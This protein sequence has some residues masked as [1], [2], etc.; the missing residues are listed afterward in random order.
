MFN[1]INDSDV[2]TDDDDDSGGGD[3][4]DSRQWLLLYTGRL[5]QFSCITPLNNA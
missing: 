2:D 4:D 5:T 1:D 3:D